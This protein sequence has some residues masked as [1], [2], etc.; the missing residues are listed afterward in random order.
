MTVNE[1]KNMNVKI[2]G[3]AMPEEFYNYKFHVSTEDARFFFE[4]FIL[5]GNKMY[6]N[7]KVNLH[8]EN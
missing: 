4:G 6:E 5:V 3:Y 2:R 7:K 8:I 1:L